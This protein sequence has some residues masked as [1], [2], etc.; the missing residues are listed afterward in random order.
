MESDDELHTI[1]NASD[2][3]KLDLGGF[4]NTK[5]ALQKY[6]KVYG[7]YEDP[8]IYSNCKEFTN[9]LLLKIFLRVILFVANR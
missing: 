5:A 7:I 2:W 9:P 8:E 1:L 3:E 4:S 6:F